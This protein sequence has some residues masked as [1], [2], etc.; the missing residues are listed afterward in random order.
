MNEQVQTTEKPRSLSDQLRLEG[1]L[2]DAIIIAEGVEFPVHKIILCNCTPYFCALFTRWSSAEQKVF[3]IPGISSAMMRLILDYA[4]TNSLT[5]TEAN[6]QEL[7]Q[8]ADQLNVHEVVHVCCMFLKRLMRPDNCIGIWRYATICVHTELRWNAFEYILQHFEEIVLCDEFLQLSANELAEI[9]EKDNLNVTKENKVY[10]ALLKWTSHDLPERESYFQLLMTKIRLALFNIEYFKD[11]LLPNVLVKKH[12]VG[13]LSEAMGTMSQLILFRTHL[14]SNFGRP[15]RPNTILLAIGGW[16][17]GDPTNAIEAYDVRYDRWTNVGNNLERPCAYHGAAFLNGY[18]YCIGGFNRV[19]HFN[20]VRKFDPIA[21]TWHEVAPM[22]HR[23]CYVSVTVLNGCI[24]AMGGYN[25]HGR[26]NTAEFYKPETNQW[27]LIAPMHEQRSDASCTTLHNKIYICGGFNGT[28]CL[29]TAEFYTPETNQWTLIAP[30]NSRRSGIG[31]I[32]YAGHVFAVGGFDGNRRLRTAEAFNPETNLWMN[33]GSMITT[34]SN[35]GIEVIEDRLFVVG[36]FNGYTTCYN[37][38]CY[39]NLTDVWTEAC[40]M[41]IFRSALSCC[42]I[43][44]LPNMADYMVSRDALLED[45]E[46]EGE[47]EEEEEEEE[48]MEAGH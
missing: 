19:E 14:T 16:S 17:G 46:E 26:L 39:N 11:K 27:N 4:Y 6:V 40:D 8:A 36:G 33:V 47:E 43:T 28:E 42:V 30:M 29:Q 23:R 41:E 7:L 20:S 24:Y 15:R 2:T 37:V 25:G 34:R 22:H 1:K 35:F 10:E 44:G 21:Y 38:E 31:V 45:E 18:V 12:C 5:V 3:H 9:I 48:E 32:A 13:L